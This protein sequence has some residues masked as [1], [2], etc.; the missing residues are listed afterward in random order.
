MKGVQ[1]WFYGAFH[2]LCRANGNV[3][4]V[5]FAGFK[6]VRCVACGVIANLEAVA[7]KYQSYDECIKEVPS[8]NGSSPSNG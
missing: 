5:D 3:D 8:G 6:Y 2:P 1:A 4:V 7:P